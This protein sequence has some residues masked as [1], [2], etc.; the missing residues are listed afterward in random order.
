MIDDPAKRR[1]GFSH[2]GAGCDQFLEEGYGVVV[3]FSAILHAAELYCERIGER[4]R[5]MNDK[6]AGCIPVCIFFCNFC[7]TG[8]IPGN[9]LIFFRL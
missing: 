6:N 2:L 4:Y 1:H 7:T 9:R 3:V 5:G 8:E